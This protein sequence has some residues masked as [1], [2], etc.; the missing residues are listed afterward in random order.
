MS[1]FVVFCVC[2]CDYT[3]LKQSFTIKINAVTNVN[4]ISIRKAAEE[5]SPNN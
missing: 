2:S 5:N 3:E 4:P 1:Q